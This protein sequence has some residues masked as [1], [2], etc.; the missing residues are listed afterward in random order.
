MRF[1]RQVYKVSKLYVITY[2]SPKIPVA[3]P[4]KMVVTVMWPGLKVTQDT[5]YLHRVLCPSSRARPLSI[6]NISNALCFSWKKKTKKNTNTETYTQREPHPNVISIVN[7]LFKNKCFTNKLFDLMF[8]ATESILQRGWRLI[9]M[10]HA[11]INRYSK[12][13]KPFVNILNQ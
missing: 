3:N 11:H 12:L 2:D 8:P 6:N 10:W 5:F 13:Q 7:I 1:L 4:L 9:V